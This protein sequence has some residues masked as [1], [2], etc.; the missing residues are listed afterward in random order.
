MRL[1][2]GE[3]TLELQIFSDATFLEASWLEFAG[4]FSVGR[5]GGSGSHGFFQQMIG[6]VGT[7]QLFMEEMDGILLIGS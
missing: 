5:N 7:A 6:P 4:P 3:K 2:P 1:L